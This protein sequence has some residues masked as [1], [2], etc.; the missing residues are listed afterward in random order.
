MSKLQ[1]IRKFGELQSEEYRE[2]GIYVQAYVPVEIYENV[3]VS[4]GDS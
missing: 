1:L 2:D 3:K 4:L